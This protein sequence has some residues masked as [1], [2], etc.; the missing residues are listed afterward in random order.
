MISHSFSEE[1]VAGAT[2]G[3]KLLAR[4][5]GKDVGAPVMAHE[6]VREANAREGDRL[7]G[8][9]SAVAAYVWG[10]MHLGE[11]NSLDAWNPMED[12]DPME[13]LVEENHG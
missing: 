10:V 1:Y 8:F 9:L 11:P 2:E 6:L 12:L 3:G 7:A 13:D 5:R 4:W